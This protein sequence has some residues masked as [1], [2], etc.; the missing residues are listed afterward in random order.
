ML[1]IKCPHSVSNT[2]PNASNLSYLVVNGSKQTL[3]KSHQYYSQIQQQIGVTGR[4]WCDFFVYS[5][6]GFHLERIHFDT[7]RWKSLKD[8]AEYFFRHHIAPYL[9]QNKEN[10]PKP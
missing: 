8:G 3:S 9:I 7:D 2:T 1:E 6:Y 4:K 10:W 5:R